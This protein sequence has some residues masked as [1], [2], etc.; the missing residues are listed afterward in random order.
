MCCAACGVARRGAAPLS[1]E[2]RTY[3]CPNMTETE[4]AREVKPAKIALEDELK[5]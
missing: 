1:Q 5:L 4:R 2:H 3:L